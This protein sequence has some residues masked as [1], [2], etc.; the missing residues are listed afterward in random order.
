MKNAQDQNRGGRSDRGDSG[1][2]VF[3][4]N[5]L[6]RQDYIEGLKKFPNAKGLFSFPLFFFYFYEFY[7]Y[8][9]S[10]TTYLPLSQSWP[11]SS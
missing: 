4:Q 5:R 8:L 3:S 2:P 7:F 6:S 11:T 9:F 10:L 1:P